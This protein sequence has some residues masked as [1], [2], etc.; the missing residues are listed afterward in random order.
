MEQVLIVTLEK[1]NNKWHLMYREDKVS[2]PVKPVENEEVRNQM[3]GSLAY[4]L[5]FV[6]FYDF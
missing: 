6:E 1:K 2:L 5:G 3:H 4:S